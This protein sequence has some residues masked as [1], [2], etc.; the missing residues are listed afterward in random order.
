MFLC[1]APPMI[2][3]RGFHGEALIAKLPKGRGASVEIAFANGQLVRETVEIPEGD[4][5][6]P[7]SRASLERKS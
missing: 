4:A 2:E 6:R 1:R 3:V 5:L 7:L